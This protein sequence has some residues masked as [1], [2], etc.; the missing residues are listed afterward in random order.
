MINLSRIDLNLLVVLDTIIAEGGVGH[1][2]RKL[3]LTQPTISHALARL[4]DLFGDPL[5]VRRGRT[6][7]PTALTRS[8]GGPLRTALNTVSGV[9]AVGGRFDPRQTAATFTVAMRDP[10]ELVVLPKL[11]RRLE[12]TA[13]HVEVRSIQARRRNLEEALAD[14][15]LD[16][17]ID[18][19]LPLSDR[20]RRQKVGSDGFVVVARRGH[21][22]VGKRLT[23]ARYLD[24]QHV[25]VTSRRQGPAPE[26]LALGQLGK[27]RRVRLRCRSYAAAFRVV[28]QSDLVLTMPERHA[29]LLSTATKTRLHP[30]PIAMPTLDVYL[31]WHET[32][33]ADPANL[34]LRGEM[35]L[36]LR[37]KLLSSANRP[38]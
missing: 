26:D 4:R 16:V 28:E 37:R 20:V 12:S 31:Y 7:V 23:L 38:K 8:L 29:G 22:A 32:M 13:P 10:M 36:A 21:P 27:H 19:P 14:G 24:L 5:F 11:A 3:N 34:W 2:A 1:A 33:D 15:T 6:L 35:L 9:L 30:M 17:A 25:M 18:V